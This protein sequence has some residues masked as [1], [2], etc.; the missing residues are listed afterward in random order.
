MAPKLPSS[1]QVIA[2]LDDYEAICRQHG[3]YIGV[4]SAG[5]GETIWIVENTAG[6]SLGFQ[7]HIQQLR[8]DDPW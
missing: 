3:L 4:D 1:E 2:F 6:E 7:A 8:E 5:G